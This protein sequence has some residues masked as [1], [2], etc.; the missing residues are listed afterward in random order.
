MLTCQYPQQKETSGWEQVTRELVNKQMEKRKDAKLDRKEHAT[1]EVL[2]P[3][4]G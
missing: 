3:G 2:E 4:K 1:C